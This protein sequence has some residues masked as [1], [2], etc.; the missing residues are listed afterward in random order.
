LDI[1]KEQLK[2]RG[3]NRESYDVTFNFVDE[4]LKPITLCCCD[5]DKITAVTEF[6][7][8]AIPERTNY[9]IRFEVK[10]ER[11][12]MKRVKTEKEIE[13]EKTEYKIDE[14]QEPKD[15]VAD[16]IKIDESI[17]DDREF[18]MADLGRTTLRDYGKDEFTNKRERV[19]YPIGFLKVEL[20]PLRKLITHV[21]VKGVSD[22][23][24]K[25]RCI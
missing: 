11:K 10:N 20:V 19:S 16:E 21:F 9:Y 17:K 4:S 24:K 6:L 13:E 2:E 3:M 12:G 7:K 22:D 14:S 15:D 1:Y 25:T 18:Q 5:T 8:K 23:F